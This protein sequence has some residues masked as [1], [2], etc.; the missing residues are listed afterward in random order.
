MPTV[1]KYKDGG[2]G[3]GNPFALTKESEDKFK[4]HELKGDKKFMRKAKIDEIKT[5][6]VQGLKGGG[7]EGL[8]KLERQLERRARRKRK[9]KGRQERRQNKRRARKLGRQMAV[10]KFNEDVLGRG[11]KLSAKEAGCQGSGCGA[12]E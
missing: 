7:A 3:P 11:N 1:K 4:A 8:K 5:G 2:K 9:R 12:Y 6:I 10:R